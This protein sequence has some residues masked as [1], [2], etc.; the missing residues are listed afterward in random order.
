MVPRR[1]RAPV[2]LPS[3]CCQRRAVHRYLASAA[4]VALTACGGGGPVTDVDRFEAANDAL[5]DP[6]C[7]CQQ[8][9]YGGV[10]ETTCRAS[11]TSLRPDFEC[12]R[13]ETPSAELQAY[14]ECAA[15]ADEAYLAC[16][17]GVCEMTSYVPCSAEWD[18]RSAC[19]GDREPTDPALLHPCD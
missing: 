17:G 19:A 1:A 15:D 16:L 4:L 7:A 18:L 14:I 13:R 11:L 10:S 2:A 9:L 12:Y 6:V 5:L 8:E 3:R